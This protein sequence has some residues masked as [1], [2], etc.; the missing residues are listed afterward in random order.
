VSSN[1]STEKKKSKLE[2]TW[3]FTALSLLPTKF[4]YSLFSYTCHMTCLIPGDQKPL[5][6]SEVGIQAPEERGFFKGFAITG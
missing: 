1:S 5:I 3:F 2:W 6:V 4:H